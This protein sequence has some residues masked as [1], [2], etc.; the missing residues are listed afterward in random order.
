[1]GIFSSFFR[2][3]PF[4]RGSHCDTNS[5]SDVDYV[6]DDDIDDEIDSAT[7]RGDKIIYGK[8]EFHSAAET[9]RFDDDMKQIK[10][11]PGLW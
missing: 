6:E 7:G 3:K 4:V 10:Q 9:Q 2:P 8:D 1:M 5:R 11:G